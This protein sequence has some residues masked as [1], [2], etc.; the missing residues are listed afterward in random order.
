MRSDCA[1]MRAERAALRA[2]RDVKGH[3]GFLTK[4]V[5]RTNTDHTGVPVAVL[6]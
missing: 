5:G 3:G 2:Q 1:Y 6:W 4:W